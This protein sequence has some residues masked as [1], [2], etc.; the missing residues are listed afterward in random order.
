MDSE[1]DIL[2][3]NSEE[4]LESNVI[5][6]DMQDEDNTKNTLNNTED[7]GVP[8]IAISILKSILKKW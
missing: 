1:D 6:I 5:T 4:Q 7:T 3:R 2:T 8:Q